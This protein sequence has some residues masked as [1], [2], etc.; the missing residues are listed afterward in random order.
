MRRRFLLART[1]ALTGLLWASP[2]DIAAEC[3]GMALPEVLRVS[4][5]HSVFAGTFVKKE[6]V[7]RFS[8]TVD[9][10]EP[11]I[12]DGEEALR[13]RTAFG[14]RLTFQVHHVWK[15]PARKTAVV[16]QVLHPD[17]TDHW[18]PN[19]VYL[20]LANEL[21]GKD[22]SSVF[23][24]PG[25]EAYLVQ[26]CSGTRSWTADVER[27]V[28]RAF[29]AAANRSDSQPVRLQPVVAE[30]P[31]QICHAARSDTQIPLNTVWI[32]NRGT[33][34]GRH[35]FYGSPPADTSAKSASRHDSRHHPVSC[36]RLPA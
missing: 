5:G 13:D 10:L 19:T 28:R 23:L 18:K 21:R 29:G 17:S 31:R 22:R 24:A 20:V 25:E 27:E 33:R 6:V 36:P 4:L 32:M 26:G 7:S 3:I 9:G 30:A 35:Y 12:G 2:S 1:V 8:K 11:V 14:L 34:W 15:G 16:Y